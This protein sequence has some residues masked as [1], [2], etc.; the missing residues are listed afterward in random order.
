MSTIFLQAGLW[1][2][3]TT[4]VRKAKGRADVAVAYFGKDGCDLLPLRAGSRLVVDASEAALKSGQTYP[5]GLLKL[6]RKGV[7]IYSKPGLHAKVFVV[8]NRAF[9]GSANASKYSAHTLVEA[10]LVTDDRA[11]VRQVS[12]FINALALHELGE[13]ELK[14]LMTVY[15]PPKVIGGKRALRTSA[16]KGPRVWIASI[17]IED[18]PEAFEDVYED[19]GHVARKL[20]EH[21]RRH[22]LD[23]FW[24]TGDRPY[25]KGD[26][27]IQIVREKGE[28]NRVRPPGT[29]LHKVTRTRNGQRKTF[30][31]LES[32][33]KRDRLET[34]FAKQIGV[35]ARGLRPGPL[36]QARAERML[37]AWNTTKR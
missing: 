18:I 31:Y 11:T 4:A 30:I 22:V 10:A 17:T 6:Y 34:V 16:S 1:G 9:V 7:A 5:E 26:I 20:M 35:G 21:P 19:E 24:W 29:V 14:R 25:A 12:G 3:L 8:G 37:R 28:P 13:A 23:D 27:I 32:P 33:N 15:R 36:G 2:Q